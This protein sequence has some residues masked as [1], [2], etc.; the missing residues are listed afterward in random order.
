MTDDAGM[1]DRGR[2]R[3]DPS[4]TLACV[5]VVVCWTVGPVFIKLLSGHVDF[6]T[7]NFLRYSVACLFWLPVLIFSVRRGRVEKSL[8]KRAILPAG[9]NVIAQCLWAF[10]LYYLD[11]AFMVLLSKVSVFWVAIFAMLFFREERGLLVSGRFWFGLILSG[12]GLTGVL[13]N[14]TGFG[15]KVTVTGVMVVLCW[16]VFWGLYTV[17]VRSAFRSTDSRIG[18]AIISLYTVVGLGV[19]D[20]LFGNW[21]AIGG[22]GFGPWAYIVVSGLF[23]IA[24]SHVLYYAAMRRVGATIPSVALLVTPFTVLLISGVVFG[25]TLGPMQWMFGG[26]LLAGAAVAILAQGVVKTGS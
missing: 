24:F 16:S 17:T 3:V 23:S 25:E 15:S 26:L 10:S 19:C 7:Q 14:Q 8:W 9:V 5:A 12:I 1:N 4:G 21:Q 22:L 20:L 11:A 13:I 6:W 18:F 2:V